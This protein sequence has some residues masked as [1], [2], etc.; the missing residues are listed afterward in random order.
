MW[1]WML[2]LEDEQDLDDQD[3]EIGRDKGGIHICPHWGEE[4]VTLKAGAQFN[5]HS[6]F[7]NDSQNDSQNNSQNGIFRMQF[8]WNFANSIEK[9]FEMSIEFQNSYWILPLQS[10]VD[11]ATDG[12]LILA[13]LAARRVLD[14]GCNSIRL[15][16]S[17]KSSRTFNLKRRHVQSPDSWIFLPAAKPAGQ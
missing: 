15:K 10:L 13:P 1:L 2:P 17:R 5:S 4:G 11:G 6:K 7:R 16:L 8:N 3:V 14:L 12:R 9:S